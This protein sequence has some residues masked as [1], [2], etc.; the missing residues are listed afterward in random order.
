MEVHAQRKLRRRQPG[1]FLPGGET[2]AHPAPAGTGH[3]GVP[4]R[5]G[6]GDPAYLFYYANE[7]YDQGKK[8]E[9][10]D[11]YRNAAEA[12]EPRAFFWAGYSYELGD[13]VPKDNA[14]A[15]QYYQQALSAPS[16]KK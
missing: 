1:Q 12:G 7:L 15:A 8:G 13:G 6:A 11:L 16:R 4:L 2:G 10:F 9:A 14:Q 3:R 5:G